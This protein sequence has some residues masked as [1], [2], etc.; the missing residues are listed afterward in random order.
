M[1]VSNATPVRAIANANIFF[2][3]GNFKV[4]SALNNGTNTIEVFSIKTT[5]EAL[6]V[7]KPVTSHA[8]TEV[9]AKDIKAP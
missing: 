2:R 3:L 1:S 7:F 6:A 4:N 8:M 5:L 9:K